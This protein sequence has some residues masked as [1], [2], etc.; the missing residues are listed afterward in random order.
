LSVRFVYTRVVF[1]FLSFEP[2]RMFKSRYIEDF[3]VWFAVRVA[4]EI[5]D[6]GR[7]SE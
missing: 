5:V 1:L 4:V 3:I 6:Q 2:I 7:V